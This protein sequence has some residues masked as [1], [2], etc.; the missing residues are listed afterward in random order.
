MALNAMQYTLF[1]Y[2]I[3]SE[4][5]YRHLSI[6][7]PRLSVLQVIRPPAVPT[8]LQEMVAGWPVIMEQE[9]IDAIKLCLKGYRDFATVHGENSVLSSLS[10]DQISRDFAESRFRIQT[11]LKR[12]DPDESGASES[13]LPEAAIFLEMARDLDEKEMEV[14]ASFERIGSL[15]GEFR[16]ILGIS[17]DEELADTMETMVPPLRAEKAYL[18]FMLPKRIQSWFRLFSNRMPEACPALVTTSEQ[19]VEEIIEPLRAEYDRAGKTLQLSRIPLGSIPSLD[20][21]PLEEF[22]TMLSDPEAAGLVT[23]YW[24]SLDNAVASPH[25]PTAWAELSRATDTLQ[26][27]LYNYRA[28]AGLSANREVRMDLVYDAGLRWSTLRKYCDPVSG[29]G[30]HMDNSCPDDLV[31]IVVCQF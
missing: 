22:L 31:K 4:M 17:D 18:S 9:R 23:A 20:D 21:L 25:D 11:Q 6:L 7:L 24:H 5:E 15:E 10:L 1:P 13:S 16:E 30:H 2:T 26:D 3:L 19:V 27:Y 29:S 28:E 14:E 12:D 8:W